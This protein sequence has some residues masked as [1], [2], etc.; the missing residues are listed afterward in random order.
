MEKRFTGLF[1]YASYTPAMSSFIKRISLIFLVLV[2]A[3]CS[4]G[5]GGSPQWTV[6]VYLDADNNLDLATPYN[7][8]D[9]MA[10]GSTAN[11]TFIV[12]YDTRSATTKRY[13][14]EKGTLTLLEDLGELD[15]SAPSTLRNFIVSTVTAYP[16][17]HYAI[18][19]SDHGNGWDS[20]PETASKMV[21][22]VLQDWTNN[23]STSPATANNRIARALLDAESATGIHLDILGFDACTMSTLE[24][25]YEFRNTA[26]IMVASED[27][28]QGAGWDYFD[29]FSRLTNAPTMTPEE[30]AVAMVT[31]YKTYVESP[32]YGYGDQTITALRLGEYIS[33]VAR[34][35]DTL[36]VSLQNSMVNPATQAA[37]LATITTARNDVQELDTALQPA[38]YVDLYDF[39]LLLEGEASLLQQALS[40]AIIAE[41]HGTHRP[42]AHGLSIVFVDLPRAYGSGPAFYNPNY[43]NYN[44]ETGTGDMG[45]FI[46]EFNWDEMMH[47]Y[48]S[49]Q[50]PDIYPLVQGSDLPF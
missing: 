36:A 46:N 38:L 1:L 26:S 13:K 8:Q 18:I 2:F 3:A 17:N 24:A 31:S 48:M 27:L 16:A 33:D 39:S 20:P 23:G 49:L 44:P 30:L 7:L 5:G 45:A 22:S 41:Y 25:A 37:T 50:Y 10:V 12:Q 19:L 15:M 21:K 47:T 34:A 40:A 35:T 14:V 32:A 9:M 4:S 42:G 11:V 43:H 28:V 29:L 6:M